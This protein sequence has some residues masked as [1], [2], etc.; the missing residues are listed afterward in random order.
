MTSPY[1]D[2]LLIPLAVALPRMLDETGAKLPQAL[3][4]RGLG[5]QEHEAPSADAASLASFA[6]LAAPNVQFVTRAR[7]RA[8]RSG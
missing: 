7:V 6:R 3:A 4:P 8:V 5:S 1:M 2:R